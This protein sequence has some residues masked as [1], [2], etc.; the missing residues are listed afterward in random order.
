[1]QYN[2]QYNTK[3]I[4]NLTFCHAYANKVIKW[5]VFLW[6]MQQVPKKSLYWLKY[7]EQGMLWVLKRTV[8][9]RRFFWTP[10]T[11]F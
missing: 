3:F 7:F 9:M 6:Q 4:G 5:K 2:I 10:K 1:M 8:S 11:H